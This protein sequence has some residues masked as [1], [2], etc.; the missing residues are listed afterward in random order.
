MLASEKLKLVYDEKVKNGLVDVK[1]C[2]NDS[3]KTA[4]F[5]ELCADVLAMEDAIRQGKVTPLD[6][7]DLSFKRAP[8]A[9]TDKAFEADDGWV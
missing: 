2:F 8:A 3:A 5:E 6:F 7:G 1:F 9:E 4:A